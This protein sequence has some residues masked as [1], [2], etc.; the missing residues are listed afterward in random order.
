[1]EA[2]LLSR[3][4]NSHLKRI[5]PSLR[6]FVI[7]AIALQCSMIMSTV[8]DA[9]IV[10]AGAASLSCADRLLEATPHFPIHLAAG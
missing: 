7:Q 6:A 3:K 2:E 1:M 9:I 10:G 8:Y 4:P 5:I